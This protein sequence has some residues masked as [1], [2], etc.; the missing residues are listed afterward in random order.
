[1]YVTTPKT[2]QY[3]RKKKA[4]GICVYCTRPAANGLQSCVVHQAYRREY[5]R[6]HFGIVDGRR[7]PS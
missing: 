5:H 6:K 4:A 3:R 1:M 2:K 7:K